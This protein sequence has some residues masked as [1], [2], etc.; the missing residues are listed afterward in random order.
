MQGDQPLSMMDKG[1]VQCVVQVHNI[2][3]ELFPR[4]SNPREWTDDAGLSDMVRQDNV[5]VYMGSS[6]NKD[7][8]IHFQGL[9]CVYVLI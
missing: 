8:G 3:Q 2:Q 6:W 1:T 4:G 9:N 7:R 5:L